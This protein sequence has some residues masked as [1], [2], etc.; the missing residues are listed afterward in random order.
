MTEMKFWRMALPF[1]MVN[2][3]VW[4]VGSIA[5]P[6]L[7]GSDAR[8]GLVFA[9][10]NLGL[11]IGAF[12]WGYLSRRV[13]LSI[14]LFSST[15]FSAAVWSILVLLDGTLLPFLAFAF[16]VFAAAIWALA[17]VQVTRSYPKQE[18]DP[19]IARMQSFLVLGQVMG[20]LVASASSK[21]VVGIPLLALGVLATLPLRLAGKKAA[22]SQF[23]HS[24]HHIPKARIFDILTGYAHTT[25]HLRHLIHLKNI[26]L[27]VFYVRW[28]LV[29]LAPAPVLAVYP[30]LMK[31]TFNLNTS[32]ASIVFA[33]ST[34]ACVVV[35]VAAAK[36]ARKLSAFTVFNIGVVFCLAGFL[37]MYS[38][39][40]G[41]NR[42]I[43]VGGFALVTVS[44]AFVSTGMNI[45]VVKL[46]N[47]E[48]EGEALGLANMFMSID[49]M[50]GGLAGGV[51]ASAF[52]YGVIFIIGLGLSVAALALEV[53]HIPMRK[54]TVGA[55][56]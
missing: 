48:K 11:A 12:M 45:G 56:T 3:V 32:M 19:H 54:T 22:V 30:L 50:I 46:V 36:L 21:P 43:G 16:G 13:S 9:M 8:A 24:H 7:A 25:F 27:L 18:W 42:W 33:G 23:V 41:W 53:V 6:V 28:I 4:G 10:L 44:W 34:F 52:G 38:V 31:G 35:F 14:L 2:A 55:K 26:P 5:L 49:N 39:D 51:L 17:T 1:I 47:P 29:L 37:M 20:L 40:I 15:L